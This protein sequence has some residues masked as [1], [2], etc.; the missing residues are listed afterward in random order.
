MNSLF[1]YIKSDHYRLGGNITFIRILYTYL[2]NSMFRTIVW[3]RITQYCIHNNKKILK[4]ISSRIYNRKSLK[5]GVEISPNAKIG[6]G[7]K[8]EHGFGIVVHD[9]TE[10]GNN[11][12]LTHNVTFGF[13]KGFAP[14]IGNQVRFTPGAVIVG[15]VHIGDNSVIGANCVVTKDVPPNDVAVGIPNRNLGRPYNDDANRFYWN[16]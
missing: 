10:I 5:R 15:K 7:I 4:K 13:E 12:T 14:K 2:R 8:V 3:L 9:A 6:F 16:I 1:Q 11:V